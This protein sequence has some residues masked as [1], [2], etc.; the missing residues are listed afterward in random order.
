MRI[1]GFLIA[2]LF[3]VPSLPLCRGSADAIKVAHQYL[4]AFIEDPNRDISQLIPKGATKTMNNMGNRHPMNHELLSTQTV[5][6]DMLP[7]NDSSLNA[8]S[9]SATTAL[10][11]SKSAGKK[12][13]S[14]SGPGAAASAK[15]AGSAHP[16]SGKSSKGA[17]KGQAQTQP[18]AADV[19]TKPVAQSNTNVASGAR[20][21]GSVSGPVGSTASKPPG[22]PAA[23]RKLFAAPSTSVGVASSISTTTS[24]AGGGTVVTAPTT[25]VPTLASGS[26]GVTTSVSSSGSKPSTTASA[27]RPAAFAV[28]STAKHPGVPRPTEAAKPKMVD[29]AG[30]VGSRV[31]KQ[32]QQQQQPT[33]SLTSALPTYSSVIGTQAEIQPLPPPPPPP[34]TVSQGAVIEQ[35]LQQIMKTPTIF[36]EPAAQFTKPKKKSTYSDA[37]GKKPPPPDS[38]NWGNVAPVPGQFSAPSVLPTD[39]AAQGLQGKINLAPGAKPVVSDLAEKVNL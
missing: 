1:E 23:A 38:G 26:K 33:M 32:Q 16:A 4:T 8:T 35:P 31:L 27:T 18:I 25:A 37:V 12:A 24:A 39:S 30:D 20:T 5:S 28:P 19:E 2:H 14:L 36:Q 17:R 22:M 15:G 6:E 10:F 29:V 3:N 11:P 13:G 34:P 7:A 21:V 9:I